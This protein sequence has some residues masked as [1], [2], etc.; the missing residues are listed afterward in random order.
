MGT[1]MEGV[2]NSGKPEVEGA[3]RGCS[4]LKVSR[5]HWYGPNSKPRTQTVISK[6][7]R[8]RDLYHNPD[9]LGRLVGEVNESKVIIEGQEMRGFIRYGFSAVVYFMDM[10]NE[11]EFGTKATSVHF[12]D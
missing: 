11:I 8:Q 3:S 5:R 7:L 12:E 10:G 4:S 1:W 6:I 9:P 2:S